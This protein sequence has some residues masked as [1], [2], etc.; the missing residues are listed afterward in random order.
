MGP[1][2]LIYQRGCISQ[3]TIQCRASIERLSAQRVSQHDK[4]TTL[5]I[6]AQIPE[7]AN[8]LGR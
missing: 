5:C 2:Y 3:V 1:I 7:V 6:G 8:G 4:W